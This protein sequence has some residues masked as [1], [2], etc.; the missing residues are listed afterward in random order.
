MNIHTIMQRDFYLLIEDIL[1]VS[2]MFLNIS[3][4]VLA[5]VIISCSHSPSE[6]CRLL[7]KN[8]GLSGI[9]MIYFWQQYI[10]LEEGK[11]ICCNLAMQRIVSLIMN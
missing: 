8:D 7:T 5:R 10:N 4:G 11:L 3:H 2:N 9:L 6:K 1:W